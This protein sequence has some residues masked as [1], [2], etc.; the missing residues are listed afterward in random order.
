MTIYYKATRPD[1]FDF[2]TGKTINYADAIGGTVTVPGEHAEHSCCTGSVLHASDVPTETLIGGSWPCRLFE[3]AGTPVDQQN[4]KYG[5]A[6]LAVVREVDAH[7]ALGP[8]GELVAALIE[9]AS[10][11]TAGEAR[12]L[13][14]ARDAAWAAARAAA[15]D[16]ARDAALYAARDAAWGAALDAAWDAA[17]DAAWA[18][19]GL[20]VRDL[21]GTALTQDQYDLL[22]GP[23]RRVIGPLHPDDVDLRETP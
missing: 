1:G 10:R 19:G 4:H 8:Q 3:V 18:A 12:A 9:R 7:L 15:L 2:Y 5:F 20:L 22:T 6:E 13:Y 17:L 16:A 23:W 11:L 14:A 21:V